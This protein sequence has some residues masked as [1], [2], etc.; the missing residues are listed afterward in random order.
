MTIT[1]GDKLEAQLEQVEDLS[2]E[3]DNSWSP[4]EVRKLLWKIDLYLLPTTGLMYLSS[5][6]VSGG[7]GLQT[8][9]D[10]SGDR[11]CQDRSDIGNAKLAV[12][13]D[14]LH[15]SSNEYSVSLVVF[16]GTLYV[17]RSPKQ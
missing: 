7:T 3:T 1:S 8:S 14:D 6:M 17:L 15:L 2:P 12:M 9:N 10:R 13:V 11:S 16:F 5:C 4:E